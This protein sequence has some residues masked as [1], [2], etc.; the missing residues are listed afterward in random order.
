MARRSSIFFKLNLLFALTLLILVL[1]FGLFRVTASHMQDR[2]EMLRGMEL[3]R[4]LRHTRDSERA[5]RTAALADAQFTLLS[6]DTLPRS[7]RELTPPHMPK[8]ER[9]KGFFRIYVDAGTYYFLP[10]LPRDRL[11]VRDD[12]PPESFAGM[13]LIFALLLAGLVTLFV[14]LRRSL[15]PLRDLHAQIRRFAQGELDIDTSSARRDEIAAI[16]NEFNDALEQLRKMRASRQLFLRNVM[17]ELKTPLTK[18]KL[19]LAMMDEGEQTTYLD[20][21]FSRMDELINRL[22]EIEK[23]ESSRVERTPHSLAAL[24]DEAMGNL[25]LS[26]PRSE[27]FHVAEGPDVIL[28]VDASLFVSALTNLLDNAAKYADS[29]PVTITLDAEQLCIRNTGAPL[30]RDIAAYLQ[31]FT[32]G[33]RTDGFGLGLSIA[34]TVVRAHGFT[35]SYA[36]TEGRHGFCIRYGAV[37]GL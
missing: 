16:A 30:E 31:P 3:E 32:S 23:L 24:L 5:E 4:L 7:A 37:N 11:L 13:H 18:G 21:L 19:A 25:C 10:R 28:D 1:L 29:L 6:P 17:H 15:L 34:D 33:H 26:R 9:P 8:N 2:R 14:L 22:A 27:L 35:L 36:Y 12:R 20:R